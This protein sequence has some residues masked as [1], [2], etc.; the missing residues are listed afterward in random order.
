MNSILIFEIIIAITVTLFIFVS[1]TSPIAF[2]N[3]KDFIY[4]DLYASLISL[5]Y[6]E[7]VSEAFICNIIS[8]VLPNGSYIV[9]INNT[10]VCGEENLTN[11]SRSLE[12]LAYINGSIVNVNILIK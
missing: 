5:N 10:Y 9:S 7:N 2:I 11:I 8:N 1:Y 12:Y 6:L 4:E 3:I